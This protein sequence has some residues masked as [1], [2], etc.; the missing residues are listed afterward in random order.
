[1]AVSNK[2]K[3]KFA[4][5][6]QYYNVLSLTKSLESTCLHEDSHPSVYNITHYSK[7]LM[8]Y[9]HPTTKWQ[10]KLKEDKLLESSN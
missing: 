3:H 8:K 7:R 10:S 9:E 5:D 1:M 6:S 2:N 4:G